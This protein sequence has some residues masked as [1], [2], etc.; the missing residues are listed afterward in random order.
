VLQAGAINEYVGYLAQGSATTTITVTPERQMPAPAAYD[1]LL[2]PVAH[3][4][5]LGPAPN[6]LLA[7]T[8]DA[9]AVPRGAY[10]GSFVW[11]GEPLGWGEGG[12][13]A[14]APE[15]TDRFVV[16][17]TRA[18]TAPV[19]GSYSFQITADDGGWLWVDGRLVAGGAQQF[20]SVTLEAGRHVLAFK[21]LERGGSASMG[22]AV[23]LPG[24]QGFGAVRDGLSAADMRLG[25]SFQS[26]SSL[27]IAADDMGGVGVAAVRVAERRRVGRDARRPGDHRPAARWR[28]QPTL[29]GPGRSGQPIRGA[30]PQL[31]RRLK[32][33]DLSHAL[34]APRA[35]VTR[36]HGD[37]E[38]RRQ[39]D[40]PRTPLGA[41]CLPVSRSPCLRLSA[42]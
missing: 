28:L 21:G 9:T 15:L 5:Q 22:Y 2:R 13:L 33:G 42:A 31:S 38:T 16:E 26:L 24:E 20:G 29:H 7:R 17:Q 25:A 4:Y 34:A 39:G 12:P 3:V 30:Q 11:Q 37:T 1:E 18:F 19:S 41:P 8:Q 36:R 14:S 6:N 35:P 40:T 27:A 32:H 10:V 23:Q